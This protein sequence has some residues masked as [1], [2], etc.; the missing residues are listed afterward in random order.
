M[1]RVKKN[2]YKLGSPRGEHP[3]EEMSWCF[4]KHIYVSC[5]PQAFKENG[6]WKQTNMYAITIKNG[7]NYRESDYI[8]NIDDVMTAIW[9][10]Y[11]E[12]KKRNYGKETKE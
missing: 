4:S 11:K 3:M 7:T 1:P 6:Y 9:D 5:K 8:Y 10:T 2:P 12:I